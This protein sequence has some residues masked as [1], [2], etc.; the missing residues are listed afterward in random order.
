[1]IDC[2]HVFRVSMV[3]DQ[4]CVWVLKGLEPFLAAN[5]FQA[6]ACSLPAILAPQGRPARGDCSGLAAE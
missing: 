5:R 2:L 1:M 3:Y 6:S 4:V